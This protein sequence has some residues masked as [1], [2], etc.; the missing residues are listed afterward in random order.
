MKHSPSW[1][2]N[3]FPANQATPHILWTSPVLYR[4]PKCLPPVPILSQI[5]AVH[6]PTLH[7]RWSILILFSHLRLGLPIGL[8]PFLSKPFIHLSS[9]LNVLHA[10]PISLFSIWS[11]DHPSEMY[12]SLSSS[13]CS[14]IHYHVI[15][16]FLGPYLLPNIQTIPPFRRDY[17]KSLYIVT[18]SC[19][20]ISRYDHV[21]S[22]VTVYNQF[23]NSS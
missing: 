10:P 20:L 2:A 17:Y 6:T 23:N 11:P 12:R 9:S 8:F 18:L 16:L 1:E 5:D 3:L 22:F 4:I 14:F 21:F 7:A 13:L 15:S 19:I